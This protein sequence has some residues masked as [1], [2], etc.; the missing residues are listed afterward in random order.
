[1]YFHVPR[2]SNN[3]LNSPEPNSKNT[4]RVFNSQVCVN[5]SRSCESIVRFEV[6]CRFAASNRNSIVGQC[7]NPYTLF[8]SQNNAKGGYNAG[9]K[10]QK[11]STDWHHM[12]S[13]M[14][15]RL[16]AKVKGPRYT[17]IVHVF[18]I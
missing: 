18:E 7:C 1:M 13:S 3:R 6:K 12:V 9:E 8:F 16:F 11:K 2:G 15:L 14:N 5:F 17:E 4:N 10:S